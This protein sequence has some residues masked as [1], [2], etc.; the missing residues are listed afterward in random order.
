MKKLLV[1]LL[2]AAAFVGAVG[3]GSYH[4]NA[5]STIIAGPHDGGE[6]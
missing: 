2:I 3:A 4:P 1:A 5:G 6:I